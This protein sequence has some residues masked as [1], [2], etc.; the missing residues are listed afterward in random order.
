MRLLLAALSCPKGDVESNL[1]RHC[2]LIKRG[3]DASCG[4]V[5][6]PEMS[7]TGYCAAAAISLGHPAVETLVRATADAPALCF[8]LAEKAPSGAPYITQVVAAEG[9]LLAVH[10][11]AALG[12]GESDEFQPGTPSGVFTIGEVSC[13]LAICAEIGTEAPYVLE[14]RLV[15]GPSAPGLYG[16]RRQTDDDWRRGFDWWHGSVYDDATRLLGRDQLLAVSTQ[17]GPTDDEDFPGWAGLIGPA[18]RTLAQLADWQ[19]GVLIATIPPT[20]APR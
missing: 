6:L 8:G 2:D 11:K 12:E 9:R 7:L 17:A 13:S 19:E 5:L 14:V 15:L 1:A 16:N 4:L 3:R 18:G 20:D 10:R